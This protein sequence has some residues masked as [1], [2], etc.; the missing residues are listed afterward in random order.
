MFLDEPLIVGEITSY[1]GGVDEVF[2]LLRRAR[3]VEEKYGKA[4]RKVL[5][6]LTAPRKVAREIRRVA[7]E[8]GV[9]VIIGKI[10]VAPKE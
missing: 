4:S 10:T 1:A 2:K 7:R 3:L 8:N 9:E 6:V 5:V